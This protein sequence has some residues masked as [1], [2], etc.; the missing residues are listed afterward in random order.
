VIQGGDVAADDRARALEEGLRIIPGSP[1]RGCA[2]RPVEFVTGC[3]YQQS[4]WGEALCV[5]CTALLRYVVEVLAYDDEGSWSQEGADEVFVLRLVDSL[6][7][8]ERP[9]PAMALAAWRRVKGDTWAWVRWLRSQGAVSL[10][11]PWNQ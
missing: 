8:A 6:P 4:G 3:S 5:R 11:D 7:P 2:Q 9:V 1:C 10:P